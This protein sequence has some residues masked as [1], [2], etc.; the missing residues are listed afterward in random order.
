[1]GP[2]SHLERGV[3]LPNNQW[4]MTPKKRNH[5][6]YSRKRKLWNRKHVALGD[7]DLKDYCTVGSNNNKYV[8]S[9]WKI[10][11]LSKIQP[12]AERKTLPS[13]HSASF[14]MPQFLFGR[15]FSWASS[16]IESW[17][18]RSFVMIIF[19]KRPFPILWE[20]KYSEVS[21]ILH[22]WNPH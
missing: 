7:S 19:V 15:D 4:W 18:G 1:M 22:V 6:F 3:I 12:R 14:P 20:I 17:F 8:K 16:D 10:N 21:F 13:F 11:T 9:L 2:E 5:Q